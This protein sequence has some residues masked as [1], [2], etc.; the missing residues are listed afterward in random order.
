MRKETQRVTSWNEGLQLP[1]AQMHSGCAVAWSDSNDQLCKWPPEPDKTSKWGEPAQSSFGEQP[2]R[3]QSW[4]KVKKGPWEEL[5]LSRCLR[6]WTS[7]EKG[8]WGTTCMP[9]KETRK[10][11]TYGW[12]FTTKE[13]NLSNAGQ[14]PNCITVH[15]CAHACV[16]KQSLEACWQFGDDRRSDT[17]LRFSYCLWCLLEM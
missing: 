16:F 5:N 7:G 13:G 9:G 4:N 14:Q 15:V 17:T 6:A 10:D 2:T 12:W 11:S 8:K 1:R 3:Q